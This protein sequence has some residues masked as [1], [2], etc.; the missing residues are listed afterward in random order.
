MHKNSQLPILYQQ[1]REEVKILMDEYK[2]IVA[3]DKNQLPEKAKNDDIVSAIE[4][5]LGWIEQSGIKVKSVEKIEPE[6]PEWLKPKVYKGQKL[7]F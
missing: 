5:E 2:I 4:Q 7:P 1:L 3:I 6:T